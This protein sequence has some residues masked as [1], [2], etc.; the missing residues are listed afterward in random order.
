MHWYQRHRQ[1]PDTFSGDS[2][3]SVTTSSLS[4]VPTIIPR[5]APPRDRRSDGSPERNPARLNNYVRGKRLDVR[6]RHQ[7]PGTIE[8]DQTNQA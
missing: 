1:N 7:M 5:W 8:P 2:W 6:S 3:D 4:S